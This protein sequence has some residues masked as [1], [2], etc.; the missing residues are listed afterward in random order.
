MKKLFLVILL[1]TIMIGT[2]QSSFITRTSARSVE[3]ELKNKLDEANQ[4][5]KHLESNI[6]KAKEDEK[7]LQYQLFGYTKEKEDIEKKMDQK[8]KDLSLLEQKLNIKQI[9]FNLVTNQVD[10]LQQTI[11][12]K[13]KKMKQ[14]LTILYKNYTLNYSA[15]LFSAKSFNEILDKSLYLQYLFQANKTYFTNFTQQKESLVK[16]KADIVPVQVQLGE[17]RLQ[18]Q[19][20][21]EE[22][23][24]LENQK[25]NAIQEVNSGMVKNEQTIAQ[26]Y[27]EAQ[28][29]ENYVKELLKKIAEEAR[30]KKL[31]QAP[32]GKIQ[33]PLSGKVTSGFGNR[34]HPIFGVY[35][36]HTGIDIDAD[37]GTPIHAIA[38]GI[39]V[40]AGWL[41]GYGNVV[42]LQH[43][44]SHSSLYAH[45]RSYYVALEQTVKI[46]EVIG[47]VGTTGWSTGPHL[48][49]EI[50]V[51]GEPDN[52][53]NYLPK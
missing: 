41:S 53:L 12:D 39:V 13:E 33:W 47:E 52:P 5:L 22:L 19:N 28:K 8:G 38:N 35:R 34:L 11:L 4:K 50:R 40:F 29:T 25:I 24:N 43:D 9:E 32:W 42:I 15:F 45:Q 17:L 30:K 49:L 16:K 51:N 48:H 36:M 3:E 6:K 18:N 26:Y 21:K 1:F 31:G 46:G 23:R 14:I 2:A 7:D 44:L 10:I 37:S 20:E 27:Q